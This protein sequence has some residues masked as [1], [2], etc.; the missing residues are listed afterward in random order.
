M[1]RAAL[2]VSIVALLSFGLAAPVLAAAP[3]SDTYAGR[4]TIA[5][6]PFSDTVDTTEA[7]TDADDAE[8][9]LSC[10][11]P[12]TDA[13][14][15]Y[16]FT[17]TADAALVV[18]VS[19]SDYSA[20][21]IVAVGTPGGNLSIVT[22]G[23]GSAFF[24][25]TSGQT[26]LILAFDDQQDGIGNGGTL[27]LGVAAEPPP[28]TLEVTI[29]SSGTFNARSGVATISGA[30]M[31]TGGEESGKNFI[32]VQATQ[33]VGRVKFSGSGFALFTCD[34]TTQPWAAQVISDT[35][36]FAGGKADVAMFALAC[37]L[38]GCAEVSAEARVTLRKGR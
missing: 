11:A 1:R 13:S 29:A 22:C 2:L 7:T 10:G 35:G 25:T 33:T 6:L 26:Y 15:W 27:E 18:D 17:A 28:P 36:K 24:T 34:G 20:G 12:A 21:V 23:P 19:T 31:C 8:A 5:A 3:S 16:E 32:S 4:A 37:G 30:V 38:T 9:N 14:V